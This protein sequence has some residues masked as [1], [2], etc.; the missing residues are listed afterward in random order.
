MKIVLELKELKKLRKLTETE[1]QVVDYILNHP[2]EFEKLSSR[3]LAELTFTSPAT[4]VRICQKLGFSGYAEFKIKYLQEINQNPMIDTVSRTN[5]ITKD[6]SIQDVINKMAALE[7]TAIEQTKKG[8]DVAQ[9][10][11]VAQLLEQANQINFFA[12]DNNL[13]IAKNA[14]V[15]FLYAGK[16]SIVHDGSN[17]QFMQAVLSHNNKQNVAIII[18]RTGENFYLKRTMTLL[19]EM[20]IPMI[21]LTES[22]HSTLAKLAQEHI[23]VYNVFK[24]SDMGPI[25]FETSVKYIFNTLFAILFSHNI[26]SI[27]KH[28]EVYEDVNEYHQLFKLLEDS[29]Y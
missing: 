18:S 23:S 1:Q 4:V 17:A 3:Q 6:D 14:C 7:M 22:R 8:F 21:I 24:Y 9:L 27:L 25:I 26:D 12:F 16:T 13:H 19:K 29:Q 15:H 2:D 11:R 20:E 5:P 28:Q 10:T